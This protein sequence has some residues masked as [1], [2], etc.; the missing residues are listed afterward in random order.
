MNRVFVTGA[1]GLL[2]AHITL[3]LLKRGYEVLCLYREEKKKKDTERIMGFYGEDALELFKNIEWVEGDILDP[4]T[5]FESIKSCDQVV[6]AAAF[7][8]FLPSEASYMYKVN[9]EG[10]A[11]IVNA[12]LKLNVKKLCYISSVAAIGRSSEESD[13]SED[14]VWKENET[15]TRYAVSK[16]NA[17]LEVWRGI[18]E[19]L[20]AVIVNPSTVIGPG[21]WNQSSATLI[22][23]IWDGQKFYTDGINGF[24]DARDVAE[25][26]VQLLESSV[27]GERFICSAENVSF[28][29][30]FFWMADALNKP[31]PTISASKSITSVV[32]KLGEIG[33]FLFGIKPFI[34]ADSARTA[35]FKSRFNNN[36]VKQQLNYTFIPIE[37][38][39]KFTANCLLNDMQPKP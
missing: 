7:V 11:N 5:L 23:R 25:V 12:C 19:G 36:K 29:Q 26:S 22:K 9:V 6:H 1:T 21:V 3:V 16:Y 8:S 39:V 31:R 28:K 2:G 4:V 15:P 37:E 33:H 34:T 13:Y 14:T 27:S 18:T 10:T 20:S 32:V 35:Q 24:V 17:E 30:L 38:S